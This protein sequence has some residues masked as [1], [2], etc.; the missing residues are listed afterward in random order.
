LCSIQKNIKTITIHQIALILL[1][2]EGILWI[3]VVKKE[4]FKFITEDVENIFESD[5]NNYLDILNGVQSGE[6]TSEIQ[7]YRIYR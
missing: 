3:S 2:Q 4:T 7:E 5:I 1:F 6:Y